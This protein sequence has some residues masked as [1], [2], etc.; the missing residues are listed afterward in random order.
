MKGMSDTILGKAIAKDLRARAIANL[1]EA[2]ELLTTAGD[3]EEVKLLD[4]VIDSV[5]YKKED[6]NET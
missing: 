1:K 6:S 2:C 5:E 3:M 4:D